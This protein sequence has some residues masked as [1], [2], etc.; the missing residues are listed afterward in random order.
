MIIAC[1]RHYAG[2][3]VLAVPIIATGAGIFFNCSLC[4]WERSPK[5]RALPSRS[6]CLLI[7]YP[8]SATVP[9]AKEFDIDATFACNLGDGQHPTVRCRARLGRTFFV[10]SSDTSL[11]G[12]TPFFR[13]PQNQ[14]I[15]IS[16]RVDF[17]G[18]TLSTKVG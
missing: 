8:S 11:V 6:T 15:F 7:Q 16:P 12:N 13:C 9:T 1:H 10:V 5:T 18:L 2:A 3:L 14:I 17:H 4:S